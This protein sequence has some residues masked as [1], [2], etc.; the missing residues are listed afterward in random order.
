MNGW[1]WPSRGRVRFKLLAANRSSSGVQREKFGRHRQRQV[2]AEGRPRQP[3]FQWLVPPES[4]PSSAKTGGARRTAAYGCGVLLNVGFG[5][6]SPPTGFGR[7][8]PI[9]QIEPCPLSSRSRASDADVRRPS[10]VDQEAPHREHPDSRNVPLRAIGARKAR[11]P[12]PI[13]SGCLATRVAVNAFS[14]YAGSG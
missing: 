7:E 8:R 11:H 13:A 3:A 2:M 12:G 4:C 9:A 10:G 6:N 1:N 5:E 14:I